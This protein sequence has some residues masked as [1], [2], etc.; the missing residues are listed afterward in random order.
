M[1]GPLE[2]RKTAAVMAVSPEMLADNPPIVFESYEAYQARV[3]AMTPEEVA[4]HE[5]EIAEWEAGR[6]ARAAAY[7]AERC[8]YC[9]CHPDEHGGY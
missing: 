6:E 8:P 9:Q 1:T 5:A 3:A 2:V 7:E 4:R